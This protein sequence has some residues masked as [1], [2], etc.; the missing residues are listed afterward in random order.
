[1]KGGVW[2]QWNCRNRKSLPSTSKRLFGASPIPAH[3]PLEVKISMFSKW[4]RDFLYCIDSIKFVLLLTNKFVEWG[5]FVI[6]LSSLF[7]S[8]SSLGE[9]DQNPSLNNNLLCKYIFKWQSYI[10]S[11]MI[12]FSP[13]KEKFNFWRTW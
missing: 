13:G 9:F 8:H 6:Y 5:Y 4:Y 1:M 7:L 2:Q 3:N 11:V 12:I 10:S